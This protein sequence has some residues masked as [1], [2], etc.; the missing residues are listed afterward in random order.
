MNM[1]STQLGRVNPLG[2]ISIAVE[3]HDQGTVRDPIT[4]GWKPVENLCSH[5][6]KEIKR[7]VLKHY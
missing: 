6:L 4:T 1:N 3:T 5:S 7:T 2:K